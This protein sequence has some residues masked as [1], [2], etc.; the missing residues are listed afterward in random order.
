ME[1]IRKIIIPILIALVLLAIIFFGGPENEKKTSFGACR[2]VS[3]PLNGRMRCSFVRS[4]IRPPGQVLYSDCLHGGWSLP[5]LGL[6]VLH[7]HWR[8]RQKRFHCRGSF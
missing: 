8:R 7:F 1:N 5:S 4:G 2:Y 6:L 3:L